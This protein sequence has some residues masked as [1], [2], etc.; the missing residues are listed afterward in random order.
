MDITVRGE[1]SGYVPGR[2]YLEFDLAIKVSIAEY[3]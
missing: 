2:F 3:A 1:T